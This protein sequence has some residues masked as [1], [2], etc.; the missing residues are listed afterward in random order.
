MAAKEKIR[1]CRQE[2]SLYQTL[3][4]ANREEAAFSRTGPDSYQEN[5]GVRRFES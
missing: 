3:L 5:P 2:I 1:S 4:S